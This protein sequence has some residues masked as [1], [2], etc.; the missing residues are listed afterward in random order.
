MFR[1]TPNDFGTSFPAGFPFEFSNFTHYR[2]LGTFA[3][4]E[5]HHSLAV[6]YFRISSIDSAVTTTELG[7]LFWLISEIHI[8]DYP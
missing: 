5:E 8:Y 4:D 7:S 3:H 6:S 2:Y 1:H